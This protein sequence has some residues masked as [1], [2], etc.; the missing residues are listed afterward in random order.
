MIEV[1]L[2][3]AAVGF[4][5]GVVALELPNDF[6]EVTYNDRH[7]LIYARH[8]LIGIPLQ[9]KV[10]THSAIVQTQS[11]GSVRIEFEISA[12]DYPEQ[13][14]TIADK[15][16]VDPLAD[17]LKR[18]R[19]ESR[20][21]RDAYALRTEV[22]ELAPFQQPVDGR[23]SSPFGLKRVLNQQPRRPHS[24]L[25]IAAPTGTPINAP[26]PGSVAVIGDFFFNGNTVL[27]DHGGGLVTMFCHMSEITV[28]VGEIVTRGQQLGLVGATGRA[29]GPHLHWTVSL[30]GVRV[31]PLAAIDVLN[32]LDGVE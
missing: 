14:I 30:Q 18:I 15:R 4:P 23:I 11:R 7:P 21:M 2:L 8:A 16:M 19:K 1:L 27:V 31:D 17:D 12:K 22:A 25:D 24:G 5:G 29:T 6:T 28:A 3:V 20:L 26:A 13:H 9:A 10:G 32:A